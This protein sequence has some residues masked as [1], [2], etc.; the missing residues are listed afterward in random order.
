MLSR[1]LAMSLI[2]IS[3]TGCNTMHGMGQDFNSVFAPSKNTSGQTIFGS[4][5]SNTGAGGTGSSSGT[6][7]SASSSGSSSGK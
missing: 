4:P 3:L 5:T 7:A 1:L 6:S 2:G